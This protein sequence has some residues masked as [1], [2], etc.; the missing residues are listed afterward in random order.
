VRPKVVSAAAVARGHAISVGGSQCG[1]KRPNVGNHRGVS[2]RTAIGGRP[3][4][5][6]SLFGRVAVV[7]R[8]VGFRSVGGHAIDRVVR[9]TIGRKAKVGCG[10]ERCAGVGRGVGVIRDLIGRS[11]CRR[12][13][14]LVTC[15]ARAAEQ[16]EH[17]RG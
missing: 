12:G 15:D 5:D 4:D 16:R 2:A 3:H 8:H 10:V 13:D 7:A 6:S 9:W 1:T 17:R 11:I 14:W